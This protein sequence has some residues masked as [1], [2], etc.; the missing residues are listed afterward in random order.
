MVVTT[1]SAPNTE[2][3][4]LR[5]RS[6]PITIPEKLPAAA[7][8][9]E[10]PMIF[11]GYSEPAH[12]IEVISYNELANRFEFQQVMNYGPPPMKPQLFQSNRSLCLTCHQ[13]GTPI[14]YENGW[15]ATNAHLANV[16]LMKQFN[17][18]E[19]KPT[20]DKWDYHGVSFYQSQRPF[21]GIKGRQPFSANLFL[22]ESEE[23]ERFVKNADRVIALTHRIWRSACGDNLKC[24]SLV[25][26]LSLQGA[27]AKLQNSG[28]LSADS[29][30]LRLASAQQA[31]KK[32]PKE[33][34]ELFKLL[35]PN[36]KALEHFNTVSLKDFEPEIFKNF[37]TRADFLAAMPKSGIFTNALQSLDPDQ[38][39]KTPRLV[40]KS[41]EEITKEEDVVKFLLGPMLN[42][43]PESLVAKLLAHADALTQELMLA[44]KDLLQSP[45]F[46]PHKFLYKVLDDLQITYSTLPNISYGR[47]LPPEIKTGVTLDSVRDERLLRV[48]A[49]C[50]PCHQGQV[51]GANFLV[52][53]SE[54]DVINNIRPISP[55]MR[56]YITNGIMPPS[57]AAQSQFLKVGDNR[58]ELLK[59]I[60]A[61]SL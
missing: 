38:D 27:I 54:A 4:L 49:A 42:L 24:R 21:Y 19:V 57:S 53:K 9:I 26:F 15:S 1:M 61:L 13:N 18:P 52:G 8:S 14:F 51:D 11:L 58:A 50:G 44:A 29:L 16:L 55:R 47:K 6:V 17:A 33:F 45:N 35:Q 12:S 3:V 28:N 59:A 32:Y 60:E 2:Q 7:S 31:V 41:N 48:V 23:F 34:S 22:A 40:S 36:L 30:E 39:P 25:I 37:R 56:E 5:D 10:K 43:Y 46:V 20:E